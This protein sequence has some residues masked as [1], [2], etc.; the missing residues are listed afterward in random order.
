[1]TVGGKL[2]FV[3]NRNEDGT[4]RVTA[5]EEVDGE[6]VGGGEFDGG[7]WSDVCNLAAVILEDRFSLEAT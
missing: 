5:S 6:V 7:S 1:M 2:E 3:W 4:Y